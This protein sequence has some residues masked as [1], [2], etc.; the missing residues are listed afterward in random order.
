MKKYALLL[1]LSLHFTAIVCTNIKIISALNPKLVVYPSQKKIM[2]FFKNCVKILPKS[3]LRPLDSYTI[4]SGV[5]GYCFFSP[6]PLAGSRLLVQVETEAGNVTTSYLDAHSFEVANKFVTAH[7][8]IMNVKVK[9]ADDSTT[10]F[11]TQSMAA[12]LFEKYPNAL[13]ISIL[14]PAYELP[15][16]AD[17]RQGQQP[18]LK[19]NSRYEFKRNL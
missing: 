7:N 8:F 5:I 3:A 12:R 9:E 1:F 2:S 10:L 6:D 17:F 13:K 15:C 4:Y 19:E 11:C 18:I 16:M 14:S